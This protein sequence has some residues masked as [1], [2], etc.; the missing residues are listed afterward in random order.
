MRGAWQRLPAER[1]E[2]P[3]ELSGFGPQPQLSCRSS[4]CVQDSERYSLRF[5]VRSMYLSRKRLPFFF[6]FFFFFYPPAHG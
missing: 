6:F 1:I 3:G 5:R 2:K 4:R